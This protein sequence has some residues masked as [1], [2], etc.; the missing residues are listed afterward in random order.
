MKNDRKIQFKKEDL[1]KGAQTLGNIL[2]ASIAI[3]GIIGVALVA[4][5]AVQ[6]LKYV[7]PEDDIKRHYKYRANHSLKKLITDGY[8]QEKMI[9]N[10]KIFSLTNKGKLRYESLKEKK[11]KRWD[12]KWRLV[13]F[14]VYE[15]NRNKRNLLRKELQSYG[16]QMIHQSTWAYPYPCDEYI[17]LLKSDLSFGKNV[18]YM[19]VEYLDMHRELKEMFNL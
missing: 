4:P 8:V 10:R 12:G 6:I 3:T 11:Q 17:A 2:L 19:L 13:S 16:F 15:K 7:I 1:K 5:N 9:N 14:D 18:Q